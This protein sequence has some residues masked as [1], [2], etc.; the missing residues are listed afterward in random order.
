[1]TYKVSTIIIPILQG[2]YATCPRFIDS[3][4]W[5]RN[6]KLKHEETFIVPT[7]GILS[8]RNSFKL[9]GII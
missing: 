9:F 5:Y 2:G 3:K 8:G 6:S 1:M 7:V 4:W